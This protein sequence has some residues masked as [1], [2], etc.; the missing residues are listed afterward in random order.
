MTT[1]W[2]EA[3][4]GAETSVDTTVFSE[5]LDT[6]FRSGERWTSK[7]DRTGVRPAIGECREP[8]GRMMI[9]AAD[10]P[11]TEVGKTG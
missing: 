9:V 4:W 8:K 5:S 3:A 6:S 10:S 11:E 7:Q 2:V 1:A